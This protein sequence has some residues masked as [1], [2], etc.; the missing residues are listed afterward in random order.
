VQEES[1]KSGLGDR[2]SNS[3]IAQQYDI[4][5]EAYCNDMEC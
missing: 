1:S 5:L 3:E 4:C 2:E